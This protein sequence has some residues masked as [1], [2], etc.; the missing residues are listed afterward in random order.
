MRTPR[1]YSRFSK[2]EALGSLSFKIA[3]PVSL[4]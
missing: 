1:Q 3:P 4:V 2:Q